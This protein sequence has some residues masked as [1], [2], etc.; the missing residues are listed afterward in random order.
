MLFSV[1][2]TSACSADAVIGNSA[3][4]VSKSGTNAVTFSAAPFPSRKDSSEQE[5]EDWAIYVIGNNDPLPDNYRPQTKAI[6]GERLLDVRCADYAI[7]MLKDAKAQ[8]V[9][10]YVTSSYRSTDTQR[11][12]LQNYIKTLISKGYSQEAAAAQAQKEIALPGCSEHNAGLAMDVVS[13]DY[14]VTHSE[15]EESFDRL[16]QYTWL[17]ENAW[18]YGFILSYPKGKENITG[19]IYEP[20]HYRFVGLKHAERIHEIYESTG[21]FLTLNEYIEQYMK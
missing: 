19:F 6:E 10:L 8:G 16:P 17:T 4:T 15:L 14:W 11:A 2:L 20:W 21:E 5:D 7:Q 9:G 1:F 12:N 3:P 18:K 13:S